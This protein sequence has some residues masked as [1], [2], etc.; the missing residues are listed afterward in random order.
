MYVTVVTQW[1]AYISKTPKLSPHTSFAGSLVCCW[2]HSHVSVFFRPT[3]ISLPYCWSCLF[4]RR[5]RFWCDIIVLFH[6]FLSSMISVW[7]RFDDWA[8]FSHSWC[9][10]FFF[11]IV[12]IPVT[13]FPSVAKTAHSSVL[14]AINYIANLEK[15]AQVEVE[16]KKSRKNNKRSWKMMKT[17]MC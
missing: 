7:T 2:V 12:L 16:A 15:K 8:Y 17:K 5:L 4:W 9:L 1:I 10:L 13:N 11:F 14:G 6:V 3:N